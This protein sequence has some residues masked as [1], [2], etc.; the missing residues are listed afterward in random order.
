MKKMVFVLLSCGWV[1]SMV[2]GGRVGSVG[3]AQSARPNVMLLLT[4]DQRAGTINALGNTEVITPH[5]N[6]LVRR[7][8]T[9]RQATIM[10]AMNGAVCAPSRAMLMTGRS[11]WQIDPGG[12]SVDSAHHTLP[13]YLGRQGYRTFHTGKWH[14]GKASF[15]RSFTGGKHIFFGGMSDH[16]RVPLH[17]FDSSGVY[18]DAAVYFDT[19]RHSTD[20]YAEAA[21]AFLASYSGKSPFFLSVAFQ[22]PHDPRQV[23]QSYLDLYDTA[24]LSVPVNFLPEHPCDNGELD[25]RDEWTEPTPRS[26]ASIKGH[27]RDYYAMITHLDDAIGRI[28]A[29]LRANDQL[30]NTII[31][32]AGDNGLALGQHGLMGKQNLYEHSIG[33]PLVITGPGIAAHRT[34][35]AFVYLSDVYPTLCE[36][37]GM[38]VPASVTMP[39]FAVVLRPKESGG[40]S[41]SVHAYKNFQR[42]LRTDQYKLIGYNVGGQT[43]WQLF[44]RWQDPYETDNLAERSAYASQVQ[45]LRQQLQSQLRSM[46]D[47]VDFTQPGWGVPVIMS[48]YEKM[49]QRNPEGLQRLRQLTESKAN[50][51]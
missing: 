49:R 27:L 30:E 17:P 4:D 16:Y 19:T 2:S 5:L 3:Y 6:S 34:S 23:P 33:V 12:H 38:E 26:R 15:A 18:P 1:L 8:T 22:A 7:G 13:E 32:L 51:H 29:A 11:L 42:A 14:N 44:D 41:S 47:S 37:L 31:V 48:W 36:W 35:D 24:R 50:G 45:Q 21:V 10:G 40:R 25:I 46:G 28:V 20:L 9:F 39:S 43:H